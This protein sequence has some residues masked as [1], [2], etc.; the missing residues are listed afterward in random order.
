M[1]TF[2]P[3]FEADGISDP[4]VIFLIDCSNS[5]KGEAMI[6]A[7][8]VRYVRLEYGKLNIL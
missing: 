5:M 4:R 1:L 7:R 8:K 3:E 2:Y 6:H